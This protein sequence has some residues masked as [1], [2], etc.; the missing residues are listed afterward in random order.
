[1]AKHN[2]F[3]KEAE[4]KAAIYLENKGYKIL[5]KNWRF[6]HLEIDI[7]AHDLKTD[8]IA[9]VEVKA[10]INPIIDP[11]DSITKSKRR[12]LIKAADQY[13]NEKEIEKECR[14]DII[15]IEKIKDNWKI[16]HIDNAFSAFD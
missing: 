7:I 14:F 10:R 11:I 8:E 5:K 16:E 12:N 15:I 13:L 4:R 2:I 9:I 1:M 6:K 3:G